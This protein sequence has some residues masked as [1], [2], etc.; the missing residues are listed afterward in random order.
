[1]SLHFSGIVQLTYGS[2]PHVVALTASGELYTWGHN[3]YGQLGMG[4]VSSGSITNGRGSYPQCVM[5][6]LC[7]GVKLDK[8][9]C[10][11]HHTLALTTNGE[12]GLQLARKPPPSVSK[13]KWGV[14]VSIMVNPVLECIIPSVVLV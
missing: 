4:S 13:K 2:G 12:V 3:G 14:L 1:M 10:G 9:A 7:S 6:G 5:G 11:G 8:V